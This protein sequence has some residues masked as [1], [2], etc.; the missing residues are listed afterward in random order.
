MTKVVPMNGENWPLV[1]DELVFV[2]F[3]DDFREMCGIYL[4]LIKETRKIIPCSR[5]DLKTL[6]SQSIMFKNR[7][8]H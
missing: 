6:G 7:P 2:K 4:K 8:G 5:L 3:T 1:T